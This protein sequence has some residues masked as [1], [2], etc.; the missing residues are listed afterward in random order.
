MEFPPIKLTHLNALT[1]HT[2][3]IQHAK[4]SIVSRK[5]GY[6]TD[7]NARALIVA[8]KYH[9]L[10]KDSLS[11]KLA[12]IYLSFLH[13]V[14]KEDG[15]VHNFVGCNQSFLD[16][17]GSEDS[18]GRTIWACGYVMSTNFHEN[19]K[20]TAKYIFDNALKWTGE[21]KFPRAMAFSIMGLY[22]YNK[23]CPENTDAVSRTEQL[24]NLIV[25]NYED[26]SDKR[27]KWFEPVLSYSNGKVPQALFMAHEMTKNKKYLRVAEE[28]LDFLSEIVIIENKLVPIGHDGW[29]P[30]D[31]K[32]AIYDQ[33]PIN[34][35]A[36]VEAYLTAYNVT[37]K[38][39]YYDRA[40]LS[41][42]WFL[43][44]NSS[45]RMV[46]NPENGG[47]F[48]GLQSNDVNKNQGAE[49]T[50]AYLLSRLLVEENKIYN[51]PI[52]FLGC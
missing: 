46:Y 41:F 24:S 9:E 38:K 25:K 5:T 19:F 3:I 49:S 34:A 44:R 2:G 52:C 40:I 14:Q 27:W 8:V 4:Y 22:Y 26:E 39:K 15:R 20:A 37:G 17:I 31:G 6:T 48:D 43:G 51:Y 13:Y 29:Y 50:I 11:L 1:D 7:D 10:Y 47:C 21:L 36:M 28:S 42:E 35:E 45:K 30:K 12:N 33:Q 18:L 23:G 16:E 32:R